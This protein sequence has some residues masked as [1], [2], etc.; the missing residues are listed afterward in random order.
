MRVG[1]HK[2]AMNSPSYVSALEWL[3]EARGVNP[4]EIVA[5]IGKTEGNGGA[6]DFTRGFATLSFS[7]ALSK[8]MGISFDEVTKATPR[9]NCVRVTSRFRAVVWYNSIRDGMRLSGC[10]EPRAL[11]R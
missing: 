2:V 10:L 6:N 1:F 4:A 9:N 5:L 3:I 7:L 8:R 11:R